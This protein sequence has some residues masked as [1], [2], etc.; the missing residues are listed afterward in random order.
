M[1][2]EYADY[3]DMCQNQHYDLKNSFVLFPKDMQKS[4]DRVAERIKNKADMKMREEFQSVYK[5]VKGQLDFEWDGMKIVYPAS[6]DDIVDEG[7]TLRHCVGGYVGKVA[8]KKTMI[9]FLR[10]CKEVEKPFYTVEMKAITTTT[11]DSETN[12]T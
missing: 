1:V 5:R 4:H 10:R 12:Q 9:L 7:H 2:R 11:N 3:L 6:L 8:A